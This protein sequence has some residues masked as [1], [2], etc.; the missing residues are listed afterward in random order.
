MVLVSYKKNN[1]P[2]GNG[3]LFVANGRSF[4]IHGTD[5]LDAQCAETS[6][7]NGTAKGT[8]STLSSFWAFREE[9]DTESKRGICCGGEVETACHHK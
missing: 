2:L 7:R 4:Y 6:H 9:H 1:R 5:S 8:S 3:Q